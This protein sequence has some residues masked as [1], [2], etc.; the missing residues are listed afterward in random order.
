MELSGTDYLLDY[1]YSAINRKME[2]RLYEIYMS[3]LLMGMYDKDHRPK[4]Y[5]DLIP[6]IG[7]PEPVKEVKDPDA[8]AAEIVA[9]IKA[10]L[11]GK[12]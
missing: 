7:R 1:A 3:D 8:E 11:S 4:R 6:K 5:F 2:R 9:R 12:R 10:G